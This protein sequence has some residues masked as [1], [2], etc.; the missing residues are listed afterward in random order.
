VQVRVERS[1][2]LHIIFRKAVYK[3]ILALTHLKHATFIAVHNE[4]VPEG[5]C[6]NPHT[7]HMSA[8]SHASSCTAS[9][10]YMMH[11]ACTMLAIFMS[12]TLNIMTS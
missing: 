7:R 10:Y 2:L 1:H 12:F 3:L 8:S 6:M 4:L 9:L 11:V 5:K